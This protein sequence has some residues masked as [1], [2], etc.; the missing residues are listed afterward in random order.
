MPLLVKIILASLVGGLFS[1]VGGFALLA[2]ASWVKRFSIHLVSFA[3]GALL[4]TAFLDLLPESL[5][6]AEEGGLIDPR[7]LFVYALFGV[8]LFFVLERLIIHFHPHHHKDTEEHH[9]PTPTLLLFGDT[10]HNF[11]D[12]GVIAASFIADP[13]L[14]VLA[15]AAVAAHEIPQEIGDFSVMLHHGWSRP[16]VMW[17]NVFSSLASLVGA[18]VVFVMR[19]TLQ[20]LLPQLL[21]VTAGIFIYIAAADLIPDVSKDAPRDRSSHIFVLMFLGIAAVWILGRYLGAH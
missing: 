21:A 10:V 14:G 16:R 3:I 8:V 9:H 4:A 6:L 5:E 19:D 7:A 20:P 11:I 15:T 18:I 17:A 2:R 13:S 12:G 1:L